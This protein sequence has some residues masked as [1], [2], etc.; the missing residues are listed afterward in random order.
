MRTVI[1]KSNNKSKVTDRQTLENLHKKAQELL[2]IGS[3]SSSSSDAS[4][5]PEEKSKPPPPRTNRYVDISPDRYRPKTQNR[6]DHPIAVHSKYNGKIEAN[7]KKRVNATIVKDNDPDVFTKAEVV[8]P[9]NEKNKAHT[10]KVKEAAK[11]I[12]GR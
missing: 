6:M 11:N 12:S 7:A 4:S 1:K 3:L 5:E 2:N 8:K 10:K 9:R